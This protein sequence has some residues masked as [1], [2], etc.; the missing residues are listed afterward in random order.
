MG[1]NINL[2]NIN[3]KTD[4]EAP[5]VRVISVSFWFNSKSLSIS[6]FENTKFDNLVDH[7]VQIYSDLK[8]LKTKVALQ[9]SWKRGNANWWGEDDEGSDEGS[10]T[11]SFTISL[12]IISQTLN[13][14]QAPGWSFWNLIFLKMF[15]VISWHF[16]HQR[17]PYQKKITYR[18][19]I[20]AIYR[21]KKGFFS[22]IWPTNLSS[23]LW[24]FQKFWKNLKRN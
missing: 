9:S 16:W 18:G 5:S 19:I 12:T 2:K 20:R 23:F 15:Q 22:N 7:L 24:N 10:L 21:L 14:P 17:L 3:L 13:P 4:P 1:Q 8:W 6:R 11:I